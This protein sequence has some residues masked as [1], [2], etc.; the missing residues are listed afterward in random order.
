MLILML[1]GGWGGGGGEKLKEKWKAKPSQ[2]T[3]WYC[4]CCQS[5]GMKE[6][7]VFLDTCE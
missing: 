5:R 1:T 4:S 7:Y 6:K 2:S 3:T